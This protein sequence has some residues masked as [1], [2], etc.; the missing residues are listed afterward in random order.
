MSEVEEK[1]T[2]AEEF[3]RELLLAADMLKALKHFNDAPRTRGRI[4][5]YAQERALRIIADKDG[6]LQRDLQ[7]IMDSRPSAM[8]LLLSKL[9]EAGFIDKAL[10]SSDNR[11]VSVWITEEGKKYLDEHDAPDD[12]V[13]PSLCLNEEER[14]Y[15]L[16]FTERIIEYLET[17][18][19]ARGMKPIGPG[20][21]NA[22]KRRELPPLGGRD[23]WNEKYLRGPEKEHLPFDIEK[24]GSE[25]EGPFWLEHPE[26]P[27]A[28]AKDSGENPPY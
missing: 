23:A 17:E 1:K 25:D 14:E 10:D 16:A 15:Y 6:I 24:Y 9:E 22:G 5:G 4:L 21:V 11:K 27:N 3:Q 2:T 13:D 20:I 19:K 28:W 7:D 18:M 8:S 12:E 26:W